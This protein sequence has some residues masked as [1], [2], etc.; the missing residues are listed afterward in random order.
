M[1]FNRLFRMPR[2]NFIR[3][4]Y[5]YVLFL[6]ILGLIVFYP[7][8]N[9]SAIDA[10]FMSTSAATVTGLNVLDLNNLKTYQQLLLYFIPLLGHLGVINT[11]VVYVRLYWFETKFKEIVRRARRPSIERYRDDPETAEHVKHSVPSSLSNIRVLSAEPTS[12]PISLDEPLRRSSSGPD[13][14]PTPVTNVADDQENAVYA[15]DDQQSSAGHITFASNTFDKPRR[16]KPLRIPGPREFEAGYKVQEVDDVGDGVELTKSISTA[17][18]VKHPELR[19]RGAMGRLLSRATSVEQAASSAFILGGLP[20]TSS[21]SR[22]RRPRSRSGSTSSATGAPLAPYLSYTP[23]IGRNS[24][25][26]NLTDAQ[27]EELGGI[28]YRSLRILGKIAGGYY[29]FFHVFGGLCLLGWIHRASPKYKTALDNVAVNHS[30]WSFYSSMTTLNNLGYTLTPDSMI[31]FRDSTFVMLFMT[32]LMYIGNTAYPCMLRLVIWTMFKITPKS[33][34]LKEPLNFLLDH[35]RRCYTLLFPSGPTWMLFATLVFLNGVDVIL[36]IILDLNNP[37]V[38]A[39]GSA[40]HRFCAALFQSTS[41]RTTGTTSFALAAIHPAVQFSLMVMMYISVYPIAI[42]VRKTNTYEESSLGIY[43]GDNEEID[44]TQRSSYLGVHMKK[45]LAFDLWYVFLGVFIIT[46]AEGSRIADPNDPAFQVFSIFFEVVSAYGNV[47]LSLGHPTIN[48]ALSG[49]FGVVGKLVICA[50][51]IRGRHR[52]L[53]YELDR[54]ITL[55][56]ERRSAD[57]VPVP[58]ERDVTMIR[59]AHTQ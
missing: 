43:E 40:W 12:S 42:S 1:A 55:P 49:K 51:M 24:Q 17:S 21:R 11:V 50:M 22:S 48:T 54:A 38:T 58:E 14:S 13:S 4:H 20:R 32:F 23:T 10:F 44:E 15:V 45:Q 16:N 9:A 57:D 8:K 36:F 28:E 7:M 18:D 5:T 47:G 52:G 53:P 19:G 6:T 26:L 34:T 56:S 59:R 2:L 35:P 37:E 3:I 41:S 33:S 31:K 39:V 30:W 25:F 29:L 27:R 46:I